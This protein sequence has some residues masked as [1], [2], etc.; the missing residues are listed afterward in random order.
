MEDNVSL[1]KGQKELVENYKGGYCAIPAIP[2]GGKTYCLTKWAVEMI[3]QGLHKPGKILIVTYMNSAVNNFKQR[4]SKA[5]RDSEIQFGKDYH[6]STI[7]GLCLQIIKEK[8]D[9]AAVN[10][11]FE[12]IEEGARYQIIYD[13]IDEWRR[14]NEERFKSF[15]ESEGKNQQTNFKNLENWKRT[16]AGLVIKASGLFKS[17]N[18]DRVAFEKKT[19]SSSNY[20][21]IKVLFEIFLL[22]DRRLK[23]LGVLDFDDML[24][25]AL[26]L[27][28]KDN[29]LLD[30]LRKRYSFVCE[31]EAQDSNLIQSELLELIANGNFLRVGD[32]NQA[33]CGTFTNSDFKLFKEFS[34]KPETTVYNIVES[35]RNTKE[36]IDLA[37][38]F[39]RYVIDEHPVL[40]CRDS[41]LPQYIE[42][43]DPNS[44]SPNPDSVE[45]G[46]QCNVFESKES[47][48]AG[49]ANWAQSQLKE[50]PEKM[51]A[52][53]LPTATR[54]NE[55]A[56]ILEKR[57]IPF[58]LLD[59]SSKERNKA[60]LALGYAIDFV[61]APNNENKLL[62]FLEHISKLEAINLNE[63]IDYFEIPES[64]NLVLKTHNFQ[65]YKQIIYS[66]LNYP[67]ISLE[68]LILFIA[69]TLNF[70]REEKAIAQK[71]A[72]DIRFS[73][74]KKTNYGLSELAE[75]L[76]ETKN[77]YS[78]FA[79]IMSE[80]KGY[81]PKT[82]LVT[83][84]TYHKS[85]GMEWDTVILGGLTNSDFP[86]LMTDK[87][88]GENWY[89]KSE[90]RNADA[91]MKAEFDDVLRKIKEDKNAHESYFD[92]IN[93][94]KKIV[95]NDTINSNIDSIRHDS[96]LENE[97]N[98]IMRSRIETI[99]ERARLL[100]VGITRAKQYLYL[101]GVEANRGKWNQILPSGY[102]SFLRN[103]LVIKSEV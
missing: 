85:K 30:K 17:N 38:K 27:L 44:S 36:I 37:N 53:I 76:L 34:Q 20:K 3:S 90:Y 97:M 52:I 61:A 77:R 66:I 92:Q 82:G 51:L 83:I 99:S 100:Y 57:Q 56:D 68:K 70:D 86:V 89:L 31:D 21:L 41:L 43:V 59:N 94:E 5:L 75:E 87:F 6:V 102:L 62:R 29:E 49:I 93:I 32:S 64:L 101:S 8:P 81:E 7:H 18:F 11:E 2:G 9:L 35:S 73:K 39:V 4:I 65:E 58:E 96:V 33:I 63:R 24:S 74:E 16:L 67:T 19:K 80:L 50:M 42:A 88:I 78:H 84:C 98:P 22:Y 12:V 79:G 13:V 71:I 54:I 1:R 95:Q 23:N 48:M 103:A 14:Q 60:I 25:M 10:D 47:E 91:V 72:G 40:E 69:D 15:L 46:I 26:S 45:N 55:M 28:K